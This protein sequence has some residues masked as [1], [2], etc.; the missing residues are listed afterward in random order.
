MKPLTLVI[1]LVLG[2]MSL[3]LLFQGVYIVKETEQVVITQFGKPVGEEIGRA[4]V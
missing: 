3:L 4:H 2:I 1:S